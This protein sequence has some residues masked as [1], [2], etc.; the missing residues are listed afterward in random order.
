MRLIE[1]GYSFGKKTITEQ[2][3]VSSDE[4]YNSNEHVKYSDNISNSITM[5]ENPNCRLAKK[6]AKFMDSL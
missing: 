4:N 3:S 2:I 6:I 1:N 5:F